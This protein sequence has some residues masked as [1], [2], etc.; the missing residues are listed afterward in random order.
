MVIPILTFNC[1]KNRNNLKINKI[2]FRIVISLIFIL[3]IGLFSSFIYKYQPLSAVL[4]DMLL[5]SKFFLMY[6]LSSIVWNYDFYEKYSKKLYFHIRLIIFIMFFLTILNYGFNIFNSTSYRFGIMVNELFYGTHTSLAAAMIFLIALLIRCS[7]K[8]F[9]LE[10]FCALIVLVS[11]LRFKAIGAAII[12]LMLIFYID[13]FNKKISISK[14]IL[15]AIIAIIFAFDQISYYYIENDGTARKVLN[16]KSI[17]IAKDHFPLGAGFA[18]YASHYSLVS[19]SPIYYNYGLNNVYGLND[20]NN[21]FSFVSDT[22]WPMIIGELGF[23]G[24]ILYINCII[25]IY[26]KIQSEFI[27][28][29]KYFYISKIICLV[30]LAI[31]STSEAAFVHPLSIPLAFLLG[32]NIN[33]KVE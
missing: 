10:L 8:T 19:Y 2:D 3:I 5:L 26:K 15:F 27:K 28:E 25:N 22:F 13:K 9:S 18:T 24:L 32:T 4:G 1:Y 14:F 20:G 21:S 31:S 16:E 12:I 17:E 6:F 33:K 7:K 29:N 23:I 30:Y 11:T